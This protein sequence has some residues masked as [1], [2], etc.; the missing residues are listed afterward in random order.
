MDGQPVRIRSIQDA[1]K[2]KIGY[3]PE[4]RL[5]EGL[6]LDNSIYDNEVISNMPEHTGRFGIIDKDTMRKEGSH[7]IQAMNV[8]TQDMD[9][10]VSTLSGGNQQKVI[11]GPLAGDPSEAADSQRPD[12][13]RGYRREIRYPPAAAGIVPGGDVR[14]HYLRRYRGDF[15]MQ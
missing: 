14:Y 3:V 1:M 10:L 8:N 13:G 2:Y 6:F 4:D 9:R 7:W 5:T 11:L 15:R 12:S